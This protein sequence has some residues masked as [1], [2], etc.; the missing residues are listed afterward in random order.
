MKKTIAGLLMLVSTYSLNAQEMCLPADIAIKN[1]KKDYR[2]VPITIGV[3]GS[4]GEILS[5][6]ANKETGTWTLII[7]DE[8]G[9]YACPIADGNNFKLNKTFEGKTL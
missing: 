4:T 5:I 2:E 1:L 6:F 7:F 3:I 9:E 8:N